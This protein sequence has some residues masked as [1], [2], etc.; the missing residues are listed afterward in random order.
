M[1]KILSFL[2]FIFI[3]SAY[4]CQSTAQDSVF[5][6]NGQVVTA[7]VSDT[8]LNGITIIDPKKNTKKISYDWDQLYLVRFADGYKKFYYSQDTTINNW[9]TREEMWM[10]MKGESDARKGYRARGAIAGAGIAGLVG[11]MTGSFWGPIL[12]YGFMALSGAPKI[13]IR[14]ETVS[15]LSNLKSEAYIMGY[16]RVARQRLKT[17]SLIGGTVGL[18]AG[19]GIYIFANKYYPEKINIGFIK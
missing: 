4:Y 5:L 11:G 9:L 14:H 19:Y 8:S 10:Y 1:L 12:P 16:E 18:I 13:R 6:M 17:R 7:Q 15:D 3:A 2:S